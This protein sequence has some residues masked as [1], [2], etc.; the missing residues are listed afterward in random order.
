MSFKTE[1]NRLQRQSYKIAASKGFHDRD[2]TYKIRDR[3]AQFAQRLM[4]T[5][6]ELS[7]ALE[8]LRHA[9]PPDSHIP[10]FRGTEAEIADAVIRIFDIA[11]TY[12]LRLSDAIVAKM[13]YN[14]RRQKMN[15]G[16][17]F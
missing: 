8:A 2:E 12:G 6:S 3:D 1:F 4:L 11:E 9:D 7:E 16:K 10:K 17:A 14:A 5:V 15:G 13:A